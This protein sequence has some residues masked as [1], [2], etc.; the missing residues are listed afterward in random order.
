MTLLL[1][2]WKAKKHQRMIAK[3]DRASYA[4]YRQFK[5][6]PHSRVVEDIREGLVGTFTVFR[7]GY[8]PTFDPNSRK[9]LTKRSLPSAPPQSPLLRELQRRSRKHFC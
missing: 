2:A 7:F 4:Y 9:T 6:Y 8:D 5:R 1:P 3:R